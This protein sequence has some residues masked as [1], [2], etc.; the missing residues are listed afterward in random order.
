[1]VT[2][3][4]LDLEQINLHYKPNVYSTWTTFVGVNSTT[5]SE[6]NCTLGY[7]FFA[8]QTRP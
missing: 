8:L 3:E 5:T 4:F 1:V 6:P 2:S 7:I